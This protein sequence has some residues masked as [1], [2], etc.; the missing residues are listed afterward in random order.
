MI[1]LIIGLL[2][3]TICAAPFI[4]SKVPSMKDHIAKITPYTGWIGVCVLG[5]GIREILFAILGMGMMGEH[6]L[7]WIFWLLCGVFDL[8]AGLLL[9]SGMVLKWTLGKDPAKQAQISEKIGKLAPYQL[10]IG[11]GQIATS[12]LYFIF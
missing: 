10:I 4:I 11:I 5:W 1:S 8:G 9:G 3:G 2:S 12:V 7:G 6:F